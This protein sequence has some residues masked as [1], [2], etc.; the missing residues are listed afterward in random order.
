MLSFRQ[1]F[2]AVPVE[3]RFEGVQPQSVEQVAEPL[4]LELDL[5]KSVS[6]GVSNSSIP[7]GG[8]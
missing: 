7:G 6:G 2:A 1:I 8:W 4:P 3:Q 5:L